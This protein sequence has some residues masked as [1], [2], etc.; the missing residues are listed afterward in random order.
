[1]DCVKKISP[2]AFPVLSAYLHNCSSKTN[3]R[4]N[5]NISEVPKALYC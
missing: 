2:D 4:T 1:L 3:V 5:R